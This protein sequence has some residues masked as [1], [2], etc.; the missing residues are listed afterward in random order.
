ML[1]FSDYIMLKIPL[2]LASQSP[3]RKTLLKKMGLKFKVVPSKVEEHMD[4]TLS[5]DDFVM[6]WAHEK[7][8]DVSRSFP[9]SLIISADTVVVIENKI[10][11]K[12][13]NKKDS[14]NMLK[15]LS[16][17][18]HTVITG[19]QLIL[20]NSAISYCGLEKTHVTIKTLSLSDINFYIK[21]YNTLDK[22]GS[23]GIQDWF[24][25]QVLKIEGCFFNVMGLPVS[26]LYD[27]LKNIEKELKSND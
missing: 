24:A 4:L 17:R 9:N 26:K 13:K 11:G 1:S 3:R 23:Y 19:F 5:P 15:K 18:T 7:A 22:A 10:L 8:K 27:H 20:E 21:H 12:P 6:H 16:G 25:T 14:K 2:I